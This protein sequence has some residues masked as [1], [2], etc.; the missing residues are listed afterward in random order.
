MLELQIISEAILKELKSIDQ[1]REHKV[2]DVWFIILFLTNGGSLQKSAERILK[3]KILEGCFSE[4][5]FD[6]CIYGHEELVKVNSA[7]CNIS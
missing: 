6:Q 3:K 7:L 4:V 2:I 5:L 1:L